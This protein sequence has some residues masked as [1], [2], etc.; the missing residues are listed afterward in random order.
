M[1]QTT[2]LLQGRH[3]VTINFVYSKSMQF[4]FITTIQRYIISGNEQVNMPNKR[5]HNLRGHER[6]LIHSN[7]ARPAQTYH[8][9]VAG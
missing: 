7:V 8:Y 3:T 2:T 5:G 9:I 6:Q 4:L 1:S